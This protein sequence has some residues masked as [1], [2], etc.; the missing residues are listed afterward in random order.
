MIR[1]KHRTIDKNGLESSAKLSILIKKKFGIKLT[2]IQKLERLIWCQRYLKC[3]FEDYI[4]VDE[5]TAVVYE[6]P[7]YHLRYPSSRP[8]AFP[9]TS[10]FECKIHVWAGIS[11][12][13]ATNFAL[14]KQNMDSELYREILADYLIPFGAL[15]F[16]S[17]FILHQDNDPKHNSKICRDFLKK[18]GINWVKSPAKSP[19]M[20]PIEMLWYELKEYIR[21]KNIEN[22][23]DATKAI[24]EF[25]K[26][27]TPE[28]CQAY[29]KH[30]K[31]LNLTTLE[32]RRLRG[33]L[34]QMFKIVK[35]FDEV[36]WFN[37]VVFK[38]IGS[39]STA[40][41]L[42]S[43]EFVVERQLVKN[44]DQRHNFFINRVSTFWNRLPRDV[45]NSTDI[46]S[47]KNK[48]D[49]LNLESYYSEL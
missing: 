4:F 29:I 17:S 13:G 42:R 44:C 19:D 38:N 12:Q 34:I 31:K 18:N 35:G 48:I 28:K 47:F 32:T 40:P 39:D 30:L 5:T 26:K 37:N 45:V 20:N 33:D 10:K 7:L 15:K 1:L 2:E 36:N 24:F 21:K 6:K 9:C 41:Q 27:I 11:F 3:D 22:E 14:F 46:N 49:K 23:E 8:E 16:N 43:H 25:Q